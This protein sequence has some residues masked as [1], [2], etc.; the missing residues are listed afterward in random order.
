[1]ICRYFHYPLYTEIGIFDQVKLK[2]AIFATGTS[3]TRECFKYS[4]FCY[5]SRGMRFPTIWYV[6][7]AKAQ[8]SLRIRAD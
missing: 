4:K 3:E 5:L 6:Q 2:T 7:P 1:M 8:T